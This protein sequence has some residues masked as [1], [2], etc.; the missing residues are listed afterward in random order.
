VRR[1]D[2]GRFGALQ[3]DAAHGGTQFNA[4]SGSARR[5]GTGT[6]PRNTASPNRA[7]RPSAA[8]GGHR[9]VLDLADCSRVAG[10]HDRHRRCHHTGRD[11]HSV[12]APVNIL[13]CGVVG[14]R[15]PAGATERPRANVWGARH[16]TISAYRPLHSHHS[17]PELSADCGSACAPRFGDARCMRVL[18]DNIVCIPRVLDG[19]RC[20]HTARV[21]SATGADGGQS[22]CRRVSLLLRRPVVY[23]FRLPWMLC[24]VTERYSTR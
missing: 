1:V 4:A 9:R 7:C 22:V 13:A 10:T 3:H 5:K 18:R 16:D 6:C 21:H 15:P 8:T 12:A 24:A 17:R 11:S 20:W 14:R 23:G 2:G 19:R